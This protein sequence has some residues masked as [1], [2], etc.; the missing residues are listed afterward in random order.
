[1]GIIGNCVARATHKVRCMADVPICAT[2]SV[3]FSIFSQFFAG[4]ECNLTNRG[5]MWYNGLYRQLGEGRRWRSIRLGRTLQT[6]NRS[7][8]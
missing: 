8:I 6:N 5:Q 2:H 3:F 4:Y 7:V 1:M